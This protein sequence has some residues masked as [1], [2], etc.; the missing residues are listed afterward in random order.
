MAL[1]LAMLAFL[2][3]W[4]GFAA[5]VFA[6]S[7]PD[8]GLDWERALVSTLFTPRGRAFL[9][10]GTVVG[11]AMASIAF[12]AGA[13]SLPLIGHATWHAYRAVIRPPG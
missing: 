3:V 12:F 1:G 10:L 8:A 9:A 2:L 11:A 7:F 5:L 4:L 6:L 13:F